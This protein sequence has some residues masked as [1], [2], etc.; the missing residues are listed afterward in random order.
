[1]PLSTKTKI[2]QELSTYKEICTELLEC[3]HPLAELHPNPENG[4][5][6]LRVMESTFR[7]DYLTLLSIS[8]IAEHIELADSAL[9]LVR[10]MI[11]DVISVEYMIL[12]NKEEMA[13]KFQK[14]LWVQFHQNL[15]FIKS[16]G[17]DAGVL[18]LDQQ[19]EEVDT[20]YQKVKEEFTHKPTG[21][22][23]RSWAGKDIE[24]MLRE[25]KNAGALQEMDI[26]R[27]AIAYTYGCWRNHFNPY[28]NL[29]YLTN[30]VRTEAEENSLRQAL[31]LGSACLY[32]L[33]T[34]YIDEQRE[35]DGEN[36]HDKLA[37][38]LAIIWEKLNR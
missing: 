17:L 2:N 16:L 19:L 9:D 37:K 18:N 34:R 31:V 33:A 8:Y 30:D 27:T 21:T 5:A 10:K 3:T 13:I 29:S 15:E 38:N 14:F 24:T 6:F 35:I 22:D 4:T 12:N 28:D 36:V 1:M 20:E 11:E 32:R 25:L 7:K 23:L 26:Q